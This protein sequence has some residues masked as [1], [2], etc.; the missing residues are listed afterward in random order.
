MIVGSIRRDKVDAT[1]LYTDKQGRKVLDFV[2]HTREGG[3][4][5]YGNDG[6]ITQSV[7]KELR[8]QGKRGPIIGNWKEIETGPKRDKPKAPEPP[9]DVPED[10]VPF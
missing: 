2:L 5:E 7:S 4:D 9:A 8:A 1:L 3:R 10:D 6:Y